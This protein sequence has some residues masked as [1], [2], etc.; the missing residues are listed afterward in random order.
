[1][2]F[3]SIFQFIFF[4]IL[5]I[6]CQEHKKAGQFDT[7]IMSR[8]LIAKN[9]GTYE[10]LE[11]Y[12]KQKNEGLITE[13]QEKSFRDMFSDWSLEEM[14]NSMP[15]VKMHFEIN[16]NIIKYYQSVQ[17]SEKMIMYEYDISK[18]KLYTVSHD[19]RLVSSSHKHYEYEQDTLGTKIIMGYNCYKV[20][21]KETSDTLKTSIKMW[22]TKELGIPGNI[23]LNDSGSCLDF[24][25][26]E[27]D[28]GN[29]R[30][31][32]KVIKSVESLKEI[33]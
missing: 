21:A 11:Y 29:T 20:V 26:L 14:Y 7:I 15:E 25:P 16:G 4:C 9:L 2:K 23:V 13:E 33:Y 24:F 22:V 1:M 31:P 6:S 30:S 12:K 5:F 18:C 28:Y 32:L 8:K 10:T 17:N 3:Y 27:I 19:G